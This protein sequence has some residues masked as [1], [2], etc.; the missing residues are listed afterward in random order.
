VAEET[1]DHLSSYISQFMSPLVGISQDE[2]MIS[3]N[4]E[5]QKN[6]LEAQ[7]LP[8][9]LSVA[10]VDMNGIARYIDDTTLD[11]SDR[12]YIRE[13]LAGKISF[14]DIIISRKIGERVV[15]LGVPIIKDGS[16]KGALIA[17]LDEN[18]LSD[19]AST[20]GYGEKGRAYV[21]NEDGA[22][23]SRPQQERM[24][25]T[26]NIHEAAVIDA[27]YA[28]FSDF[29][30]SNSQKQAGFGNFMFNG[31][32]I[33]MGFASVKGTNWKVYIGTVEAE[34]LNSLYKL[35]KTFALFILP[36]LL[37]C[38]ILA[39]FLA[40]KLLK[41][42]AELDNLFSQ[43][44]MGNLTIRFT[45]KSK[46]EIGRL[47]LS[48]NRM[49]DKIKTLTQYDPLTSLQNQYVLEKEVER[50]TH[51][52][53]PKDFSIIMI[54]IEKFSQINDTYGYAAG[55]KIL[56]EVS[57]RISG[58]ITEEFQVYRYKGDE[59]IVLGINNPSEDEVQSI[60]HKILAAVT[61][62]YPIGGKEIQ[63]HISIG[64][65]H[66]NDDTRTED[67]LKSVTN[68]V[69]YA[70]QMGSDQI[71]VYNRQ[72]HANLM[73]MRELQDEIPSGIKNDQF[74]LVYQPIMDLEKTTLAG[75]EALIRWNHPKKGLL[76]PDQF[77][78]LAEQNGTIISLDFWVLG[79]AC[80]LIKSWNDAGKK[81]VYISINISAKTFEGK[82]FVPSVQDI[83]NRYGV[84]PGL[85][86]L[87]ITE[88]MIINNIDESIVKLN[89]LRAM[90]IHIAIDDFGIGYSS[91]SYIIRLPIDYIKIDKSFVK[92]MNTCN[93]A[94]VLVATIIN[95]CKSLNF[96][97]IAEGI[98]T[99]EELEYLKKIKCNMGQGYYF[100]KPAP[101]EEIDISS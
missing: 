34:A 30:R 88:R 14:S 18:F 66:Y 17:R 89:E 31:E 37:L 1:A 11:L 44:A 49:M 63:I 93:E 94:K 61:E 50:L 92:N 72:L 27:N 73:G 58:C 100:F 16:I 75:V 19:F 76:Y 41:P 98:E 15:M 3:M 78:D 10:I 77:I 65:F 25:E 57:V 4:W 52:E 9:Y 101:I 33:L 70:K 83:L 74:F 29:I 54:A 91:L 13:S 28:E 62:S 42:I 60:A 56:C 85:I 39:W 97:V 6:I 21:I 23:I 40:H 7:I 35:T 51:Q 81:P 43:G 71:Q 5:V 12:N 22:I 26:Y 48:F 47:G 99:R 84:A 68:A 96:N 86:Q 67:P 82:Q 95:L 32:R 46:D 64:I 2:R 55:D 53:Q 8:D 38:S 24:N 59:F 90:G 36:T 87:E 69:N 45:R 79:T 20:R 80:K